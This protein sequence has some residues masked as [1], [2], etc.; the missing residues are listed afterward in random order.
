MQLHPHEVAIGIL[1]DEF[2]SGIFPDPNSA[3]DGKLGALEFLRILTEQD[4]GLDCVEWRKW[5]SSCPQD[6][7]D[8]H[9]EEW[10]RKE[11][12]NTRDDRIKHAELRWSN[13]THRRCPNCGGLCPEYRNRCWVCE[14]TLGRVQA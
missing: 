2:E 7:L 4:F 11:L 13:L 14:H 3:F 9:Y 1:G 8:L 10:R 6:M 5:F 12:V